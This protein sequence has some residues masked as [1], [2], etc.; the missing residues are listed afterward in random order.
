MKNSTTYSKTRLTLVSLL[1]RNIYSIVT[2]NM[3]NITPFCNPY[4]MKYECNISRE[5]ISPIPVT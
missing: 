5:R 2:L 4:L 3:G 1:I